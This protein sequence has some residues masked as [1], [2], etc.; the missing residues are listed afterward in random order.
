MPPTI[1]DTV[2]RELE[3]EPESPLLLLELEQAVSPPASTREAVTAP[4]A[5]FLYMAGPFRVFVDERVE[6]EP[7][8]R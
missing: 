2:G 3:P 5:V 4:M 7:G 1:I 8:V 6:T